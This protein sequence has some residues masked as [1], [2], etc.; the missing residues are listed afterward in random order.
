[1]L[2][3]VYFTIPILFGF[4]FTSATIIYYSVLKIWEIYKNYCDD[5]VSISPVPSYVCTVS[6]FSLLYLHRKFL[7][8][9][10]FFFHRKPIDCES[11]ANMQ[12]QELYSNAIKNILNVCRKVN[13]VISSFYIYFLYSQTIKDKASQMLATSLGF[14]YSRPEVTKSFWH[15]EPFLESVSGAEPLRGLPYILQVDG[16]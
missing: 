16:V 11:P 3:S 10:I 14:T 9:L 8:S 7:E 5:L 4:F 13:Q 15:M 6:L 12:H 2:L 1:M